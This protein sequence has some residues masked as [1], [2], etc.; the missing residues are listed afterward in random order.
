MV[1]SIVNN[2]VNSQPLDKG[3]IKEN[4]P[5]R[6]STNDCSP[7]YE[8]SDRIRKESVL[9]NISFDAEQLDKRQEVVVDK[10]ETEKEERELG[11]V[12]SQ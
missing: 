10:H 4:T 1:D 6:N 5:E 3:T 9:H 2:E 7:G 12:L 11:A 8:C